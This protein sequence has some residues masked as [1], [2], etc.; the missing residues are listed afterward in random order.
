MPDT[1]TQGGT[2]IRLLPQQREGSCRF[3]GPFVATRNAVDR[4]GDRVILTAV[5]FVRK[6][7]LARGGLDYF[8]VLDVGGER[9]WLIDD[10]VVVMA[11]LTAARQDLDDGDADRD[12]DTGRMGRRSEPP[13]LHGL[14]PRPL[15][16]KVA[17]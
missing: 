14:P 2:S 9:L 5:E 16:C 11:L 4:F 13:N 10:V 6:E 7:A 15:F 1:R 12:N 17:E 3:N 8:Q